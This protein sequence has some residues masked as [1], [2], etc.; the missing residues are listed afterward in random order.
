V[1]DE[2]LSEQSSSSERPGSVL[3]QGRW[4]R[5]AFLAISAAI[6]LTVVWL[7]RDVMLPLVLGGLNASVLTPLVRFVERRRVPRGFAVLIVYVV[8]LGTIGTFLRLIAPRLGTELSSFARE[9][10]A[11]TAEVKSKWIPAA[12]E[13][14]RSITGMAPPVVVPEPKEESALVVR[15]RGDGSYAID[16]EGGVV[17]R[18]LRDGFIVDR[19]RPPE[20]FDPNRFVAES[21]QAS[22]AYAQRNA[23]ELVRLTG[24]IIAGVSRFFFVFGLTLMIAAYLI[25]TRERIVAFFVSLV[26]PS[27]RDD[28]ARLLARVDRG[29]AGVVRGQ[30]I[31][32]LINGVLSAIGFWIFDLKYWPVLA[33]I[34]TIFSLVPIFGSIASAIPAVALGLTQ[35]FSTGALVLVWIIGIHQFEANVLNPKIMGDAAK[36]HPILV[37]FSLLVGEHF[38]HTT[39]A[40]LAVPC[41]SIAQSVFIHFRQIVQQTDPELAREPVLSVP[42]PPLPRPIA[43]A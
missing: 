6:A 19:A 10:P 27:A 12:Q 17:V 33:I 23:I 26:R 35:S 22:L 40:L 9:V 5:P 1:A 7:A 30:I 42:P 3:R 14:L 34:A 32:C 15:P 37:I 8:V 24:G 41:M 2:E 16:V 31:I 29:L 20:P 39:G 21:I 4:Q 18:H 13:K 43:K 36:I 11:L 38:F 28:F 25:L